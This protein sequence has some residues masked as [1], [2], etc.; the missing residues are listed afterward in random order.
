MTNINMTEISLYNTLIGFKK[1]N[2]NDALAGL[3]RKLGVKSPGEID[4]SRFPE[5]EM[6]CKAGTRDLGVVDGEDD[7][8]GASDA[9]D[10]AVEKVVADN[11]GGVHGVDISDSLIV[12]NSA[13][14]LQ[15]GFDRLASAIHARGKNVVAG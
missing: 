2:G 10:K 1:M 14:D 4:A 6:L 11:W 8:T 12:V 13:P 3:L 7:A 5:V 15:T 9:L